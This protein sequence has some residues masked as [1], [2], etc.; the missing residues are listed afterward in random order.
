ML[1]S[2]QALNRTQQHE[3]EL[4]SD[5]DAFLKLLWRLL[6]Y[7]P[8]ISKPMATVM[9]SSQSRDVSDLLTLYRRSFEICFYEDF[10]KR[11]KFW[12]A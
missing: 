10:K 7:Q 8:Q 3:Q 1:L 2:A 6:S 11:E 9:V 5:W 12:K 4:H